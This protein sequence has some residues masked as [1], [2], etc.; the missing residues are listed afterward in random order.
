MLRHSE[1]RLK[2]DKTYDPTEWSKSQERGD[3]QHQILCG[4][5]IHKLH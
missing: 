2:T 3:K 1:Y 5:N 4:E